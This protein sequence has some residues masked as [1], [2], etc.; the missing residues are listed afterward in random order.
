[1]NIA[2][3][4][5]GYVAEF[6][7]KTLGNYP[8]LRLVGAFDTN[9][10][11]RTIF[12]KRWNAREFQTLEA[13]VANGEID[14]ILNLTNPRSHYETTKRC[15]EAGKHVYSEKPLA[16]DF[17]HAGQLVDLANRKGLYLSSA[18]C[19]MLSES[20]QT[21]WKALRENSI[22]KVRLVY[23]NFD[24]GMIAPNMSPWRWR[25]DAGI[26]WPA[27]DEFETG[28]TYEHAG[29]LLTWLAA[30]FGPA[31][32]VTSFASCLIPD[33]GIAVDSIAPDFCV[34][35]IEYDQGIVARLTCSLV[36]PKDKSL[37]I[38][39]DN[40]V[41]TVSDVRD[42]AC[43]VRLRKASVSRGRAAFQRRVNSVRKWLGIGDGPDWQWSQRLALVRKPPPILVGRDKPVDFCR[44]IA[45]MSEAIREKRACRLSAEL[46]VHITELIEALQYPERASGQR[47]INSTFPAIEPVSWAN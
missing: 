26:P 27:K 30:F 5:C 7:A 28:C 38:I 20:A 3:V 41:V 4:G 46:G 11:N 44:G 9:A 13:L 32:K 37:T 1:M 21:L 2:V 43:P 31:R 36:A 22:G 35:C 23:A 16:M 45:E 10:A 19:S 29:Y 25:N 15:L 18:P 39:G 14:L 40:G 6:Y 12:C 33:K 17:E 42:D 34:G 24:D 8:D 47:I